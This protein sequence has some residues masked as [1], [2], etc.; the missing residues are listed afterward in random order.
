[1]VDSCSLLV[2]LGIFLA[3]LLW[4]LA[5]ATGFMAEYNH[6]L[7]ARVPRWFSFV[8]L[9]TMPIFAAGATLRQSWRDWQ[10]LISSLFFLVSLS[11]FPLAATEHPLAALIVLLFLYAEVFAI[12]PRLNAGWRNAS[13]SH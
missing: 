3:F 11:F 8:T 5:H 9:G 10:Y 6:A 1:M 4:L 12:V 13:K 2:A 7:K